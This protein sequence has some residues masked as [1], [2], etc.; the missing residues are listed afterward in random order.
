MLDWTDRHCRFFHR[1]LSRSALLY[2]EMIPSAALNRGKAAHLLDHDPDEHPLALQLGGSDPSEL[3]AAARIGARFGHCEIN[4]NCGCPSERV[5]K[6]AFGACLMAE[7]R[8]VADCVKAMRDVVDVPVTVKHRIGLDRDESYEFVRDFVGTVALAGCRVFIVHA[9]N[10]WLKGLSPKQ[11]RTVPPLR[12]QVVRRLKQD[13]PD[14]VFVLNGGLRDHEQIRAQA[15][16]VDAV[17]V[18]RA[19][20]ENPWM[21][22]SCDSLYFGQDDPI[23]SREC[24]VESM[25]AYAEVQ[26]ARGVPLRSITRHMLTLYN[27]CPGARR[28]R[29]TLSDPLALATAGPALLSLAIPTKA[30]AHPQEHA[31]IDDD[32]ERD[33]ERR[34]S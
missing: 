7:P 23:E 17:M 34:E 2:T 8:L 32:R 3:A 25:R 14:L 27:G 13:F 5:Q 4:L 26:V 6:G 19:A 11:N 24:V 9:R 29:R 33:L 15:E 28:W 21:L 20:Y 1:R 31:D 18:G 16:G 22:A 12:P 10:A 30:G